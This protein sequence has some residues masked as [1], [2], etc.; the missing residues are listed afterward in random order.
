ML[1]INLWRLDLW[2]VW[3]LD[4]SFVLR[5]NE[6][7]GIDEDITLYDPVRHIAMSISP[8]LIPRP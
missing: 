8:V 6:K 1:F 5:E 3:N 4:W 2:E 7:Q